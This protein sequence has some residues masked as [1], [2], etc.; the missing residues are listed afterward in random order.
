[1]FSTLLFGLEKELWTKYWHPCLKSLFQIYKITSK[2]IRKRIRRNSIW[3]TTLQHLKRQ[4]KIFLEKCLK[5]PRKTHALYVKRILR[6]GRRFWFCLAV[7]FFI[8]N[9]W[10]LGSERIIL[11]QTVDLNYRR[12]IS[13]R[14]IARGIINMHKMS[15][16]KD[17]WLHCRE[18]IGGENV[19][20]EVKIWVWRNKWHRDEIITIECIKCVVCLESTQPVGI[21]KPDQIQWLSVTGNLVSVFVF[22]PCYKIIYI[23]RLG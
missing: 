11:V 18:M 9:V 14:T 1:M 15:F 16:D 6:R 8:L 13:L 5:N 23:Y 22:V 2:S 20:V 7:I 4:F 12:I 17:W 19:N 21:S 10:R 3:V